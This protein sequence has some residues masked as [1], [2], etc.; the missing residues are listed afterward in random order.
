VNS[1][2]IVTIIVALAIGALCIWLLAVMAR[3]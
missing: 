1:R 2:G 3:Q